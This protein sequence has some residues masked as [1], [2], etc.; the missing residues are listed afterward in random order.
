MIT[1]RP[2]S[3]KISRLDGRRHMIFQAS[4]RSAAY[5]H[6]PQI[7]SLNGLLLATWSIGHFHEDGPGQ[8]MVLSRSMDQGFTW[9]PPETLM[10]PPAGEHRPACITSGGLFV[11]AGGLTA[12]YSSCEFT[13]EG[14]LSFAESGVEARGKS[15]IPHLQKVHTGILTSSDGGDTWKNGA[16]SLP[17][18]IT[19]LS[20]VRLASGRLIITSHRTHAWSDDPS[21]I[22][23]WTI[24]PLPGL[25]ADYYEGAGGD[26][27][28]QADWRHWGICAGLLTPRE[29][30]PDSM[31]TKRPCRP[32][33]KP[34]SKPP[35]E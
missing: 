7:T 19:N 2:K 22:Q 27:P 34:S 20:P 3:S 1:N 17:G 29:T 35:R 5:A 13:L 4:D 23:N 33:A 14:L 32:T 16:L 30:F 9:S 25:P 6:H 12:Y 31:P 24:S 10:A 28:L 21:G 15:R 11:R 8:R 18:F 26:R